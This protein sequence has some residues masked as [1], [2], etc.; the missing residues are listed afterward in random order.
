MHLLDSA[1]LIDDRITPI[2]EIAA[3]ESAG[4][5][6]IGRLPKRTVRKLSRRLQPVFETMGIEQ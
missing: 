1:F 5:E 4:I 6:A 3:E 2:P